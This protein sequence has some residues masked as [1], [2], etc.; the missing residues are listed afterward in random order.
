MTT[1][2]ATPTPAE[3]TLEPAASPS[4]N[5]A[6]EVSASDLAAALAL[7]QRAVQSGQS[8][9]LP[10]AEPKPTVAKLIPKVEERVSRS[11]FLVYRPALKRLAAEHPTKPIDEFTTDDLEV[12]VRKVMKTA[13]RRVLDEAERTG[14][15]L[16]S[17]EPESHGQ[18]AGENAVSSYSKL[19]EIAEKMELITIN[20]VRDKLK[21]PRRNEPP[22]RPL[23]DAELAELHAIWSATGNDPELDWS[24]QGLVDT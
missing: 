14:K 21:A 23:T 10:T 12:V 15:E 20:P 3:T 17:Y 5:A 8:L 13:A 4:A 16:R 18:G 2:E 7:I 6:S 22:E 19:F 9:D 24:C 1:N 11:T